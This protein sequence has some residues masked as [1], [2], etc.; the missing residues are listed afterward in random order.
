[1][2]VRRAALV[3]AQ[4]VLTQ[5]QLAS[6]TLDEAHPEPR[7]E[8]LDFAAHRRDG[9]ANGPR[10]AAEAAELRHADEDGELVDVRH[11]DPRDIPNT[12]KVFFDFTT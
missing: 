10:R 1:L 9:H 11:Q 2:Q 6:R 8:L 7:L 3:E 12:E 5:A 4:A